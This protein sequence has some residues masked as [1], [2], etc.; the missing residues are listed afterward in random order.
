LAGIGRFLSD[1]DATNQLFGLRRDRL[2]E[3]GKLS[4]LRPLFLRLGFPPLC[5]PPPL[6]Q[7]LLG[8]SGA[9]PHLRRNP[10]PSPPNR[11]AAPSPPRQSS[12]RSPSSA[13][14]RTVVV[15]V[16]FPIPRHSVDQRC[17]HA[18]L[19]GASSAPG[20]GSS[21]GSASSS[22]KCISSRTSAFPIGFTAARC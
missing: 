1:S 4:R 2:E 18:Q 5:L 6:L 8:H 3:R 17:G 14:R 22:W 16:R 7:A 13:P 11:P 15:L 19:F 12:P 9:F 10:P 20:S 21:P